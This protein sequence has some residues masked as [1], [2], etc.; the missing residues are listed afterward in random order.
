MS[1]EYAPGQWRCGS[2]GFH[3]VRN[4]L[5]ARTGAV[6]ADDSDHDR[7]CPNC[8]DVRLE[9]VTWET[10]CRE[11]WA[12]MERV[13]LRRG[14]CGYATF[15]DDQIAFVRVASDVTGQGFFVRVGRLVRSY[16]HDGTPDNSGAPRLVRFEPW[17]KN[18]RG[19]PT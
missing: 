19:W 9:R 17:Y 6:T 10:M 14:V 15:E 8:P 2:C 3:L 12:E 13:D 7:A 5:N 18:E 16:K 4:H 1:G 11:A